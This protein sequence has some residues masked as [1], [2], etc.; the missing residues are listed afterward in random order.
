MKPTLLLDCDGILANFIGA[1][2]NLLEEELGVQPY[3][4]DDIQTW[5]LFDSLP[6]H[7]HLRHAIYNELKKPLGCLNIPVYPGAQG[8]GQAP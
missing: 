6:K 7:R 1:C 3:S 5:D 8:C 2:L 4:H